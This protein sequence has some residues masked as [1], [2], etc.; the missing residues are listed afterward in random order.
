MWAP[1]RWPV[2]LS[3][4]NRLTVD[5]SMGGAVYASVEARERPNEAVF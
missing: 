4:H 5:Y 3:L 2:N 1:R